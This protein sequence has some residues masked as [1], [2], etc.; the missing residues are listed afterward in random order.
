[1]TL[2]R[3]N[4]RVL[5]SLLCSLLPG[6]RP[7]NCRSM[8]IAAAVAQQQRQQQQR[9]LS[10]PHV[11]SCNRDPIQGCCAYCSAHCFQ[12][13]GA[14]AKAEEHRAS[15]PR[16]PRCLRA[17]QGFAFLLG[18]FCLRQRT[19]GR[20]HSEGPAGQ[21]GAQARRVIAPLSRTQGGGL[22]CGAPC[23][24]PQVFVDAQQP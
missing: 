23:Q 18:P 22:C 11:I 24:H 2:A 13:L 5:C 4:S 15:F 8:Q 17:F 10:S 21:R 14:S 12:V 7:S 6:E 20:A 9:R 1:M 3:F 19:R 16:L